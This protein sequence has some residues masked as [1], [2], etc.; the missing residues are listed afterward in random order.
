MTKPAQPMMDQVVNLSIPER[1]SLEARPPIPDDHVAHICQLIQMGQT[2]LAADHLL[3]P[4]MN[5]VLSLTVTG[6]IRR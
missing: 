3:F 5:G 1:L 6:V 4:E 2:C